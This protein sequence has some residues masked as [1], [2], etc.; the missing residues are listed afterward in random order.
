MT[1]APLPSIN[2]HRVNA[3]G[4]G[5]PELVGKRGDYV[6]PATG[7]KYPRVSK[8]LGQINK[9]ALVGWAAKETAEAAVHGADTWQVMGEDDA[10]RWLK[11]ARF[12][13]SEPKMVRGSDVHAAI[14]YL[15]GVDDIAG[16]CAEYAAQLDDTLETTPYVRAACAWL[17]KHCDRVDYQEVTTF[18]D[19]DE[20]THWAGTI[21]IVGHGPEL[22]NFVGD[23]KTGKAL[24]P[25]T[26][27]QLAAYAMSSWVAIYD[28]DEGIHIGGDLPDID[29]L[30]GLHTQKTQVTDYR[31]R[32]ATDGE[33]WRKL[34]AFVHAARDLLAFAD[35]DPW[36]GPKV[37]TKAS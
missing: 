21:D 10:L 20:D 14:P 6:W 37:V 13:S 30:V 11:N 33:H 22:G 7:R 26:A 1:Q 17:A 35:L 9:P 28:E 18:T 25:E 15:V 8:V 19:Y 27:L 3:V 36:H 2:E 29:H 23:W 31:W 16:A 24:Y 5:Q 12:R 34:T 4:G 32:W